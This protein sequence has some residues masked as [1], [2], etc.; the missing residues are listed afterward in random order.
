[1]RRD[2][3]CVIDVTVIII[4]EKVAAKGTEEIIADKETNA[5]IKV[6]MKNVEVESFESMIR[7]R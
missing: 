7:P 3:K 5:V 4:V 6:I 1:M 2:R